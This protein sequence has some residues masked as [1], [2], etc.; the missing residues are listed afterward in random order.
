MRSSCAAVAWARLLTK[1]EQPWTDSCGTK[2]CVPRTTGSA[3]R[4][5]WGSLPLS[6]TEDLAEYWPGD[7]QA[8]GNKTGDAEQGQCARGTSGGRI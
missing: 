6:E 4:C 3:A 8:E 5:N 7:D 2:R 1:G